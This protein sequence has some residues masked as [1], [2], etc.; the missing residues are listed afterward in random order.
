MQD[1]TVILAVPNA[2]T[3]GIA[4]L[5]ETILEAALGTVVDNNACA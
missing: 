5:M 4:A 1:S 3:S 2:T